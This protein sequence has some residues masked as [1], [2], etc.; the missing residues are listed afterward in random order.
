MRGG[1]SEE[2]WWELWVFVISV[3]LWDF[4]AGSCWSLAGGYSPELLA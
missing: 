4:E 3:Q 2:R 1:D